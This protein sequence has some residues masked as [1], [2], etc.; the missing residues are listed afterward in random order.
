[1]KRLTVLIV[2]TFF[3]FSATAFAGADWQF[4]GSSRMETYSYTHDLSADKDQRLTKWNIQGNSRIGARVKTNDNGIGGRFEYGTGVNL[5]RLYGTWN[6]GSGE[7]LIGHT[8]MP[9]TYWESNQVWDVDTDLIGL[10]MPYGSR[11][12]MIQLNISGFKLAFIVP[13]VSDPVYPE[14]LIAEPTNEISTETTF[15]KIETS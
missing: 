14:L 4:Y 15:P 10:G 11:Q 12:P 8:E 7:V 5:R 1:M 13:N 3:I 2:T 9:S 6:F